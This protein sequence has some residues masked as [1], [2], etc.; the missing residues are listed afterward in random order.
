MRPSC[1][2][3]MRLTAFMIQVPREGRGQLGLFCKQRGMQVGLL[4]VQASKPGWQARCLNQ[5]L[6]AAP[7]MAPVPSKNRHLPLLPAIQ[8]EVHRWEQLQ[9]GGGGGVTRLPVAA[10]R[11]GSGSVP[12]SRQPSVQGGQPQAAEFQFGPQADQQQQQH[13]LRPPPPPL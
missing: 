6:R 13:W 9:N 4:S 2:E 11:A 7:H 3:V 8:E 12:A 5:R 1:A 10:R